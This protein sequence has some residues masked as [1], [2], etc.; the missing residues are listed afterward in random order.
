[1][2]NHAA[3]MRAAAETARQEAERQRQLD[4]ANR[5]QMESTEQQRYLETERQRRQLEEDRVQT[6]LTQQQRQLDVERQR[7]AE[8][9]MHQKL[10]GLQLG[11]TYTSHIDPATARTYYVD[12]TTGQ[13]TWELP[14]ATPP[15][16]PLPAPAL[17]PLPVPVPVPVPIPPLPSQPSLP[18]PG[19]PTGI[20][21]KDRICLTKPLIEG[22]QSSD[23]CLVLPGRYIAAHTDPRF[24]IDV[25]IKLYD[26]ATFTDRARGEFQL[27][28]TLHGPHP[29]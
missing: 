13:S 29:G 4:E 7:I 12:T 8:L 27:M 10:S 28:W 14:L 18:S 15:P 23:V 11:G 1:M 20:S 26:A 2:L 5:T 25:M 3:A 16:P 24:A 17:L 19:Q 22:V 6:E 21:D 9:D